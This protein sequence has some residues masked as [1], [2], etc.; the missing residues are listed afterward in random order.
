M[1]IKNEVQKLNMDGRI[2]LIEVDG[3]AFGA[4]VMRFHKET[5]PYTPEELEAA[6]NGEE[7]K[8]KTIIW[9]GEEYYPYPYELTGIEAS[10]DGR[11]AEPKLIVSNLNGV[12]TSLC[13]YF[14]DLVQAKV[15][16]HDTFV[17]YL[18]EVNFPNGNPEASV[19]DE[20]R[21][22]FYIDSRSAETNTQI[23]FTLSSPI[24]LQGV[25]LPRRQIHGICGWCINGWYRTGKGCDYSG[26][27]YF[28][29]KGHSTDD[30]GK[31]ECSGLLQDCQKRFG[32][33]NALPFGG[34]PSTSLVRR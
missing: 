34:F 2:R 26:T 3:S 30:P 31:D 17:R 16:I 11:S 14:D 28:D 33:E 20:F 25:R 18:D 1:A 19:E 15:T 8:P 23:E 21:Q 24:D 27:L 12:I 7:L 6:E 5:L 4:D 32:K 9:Q 22:V 29:K 13:L 10:T